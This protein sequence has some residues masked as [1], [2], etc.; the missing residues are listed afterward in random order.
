[1]DEQAPAGNPQARDGQE[2]AMGGSEAAPEAAE[3]A[4]AGAG[5]EGQ[6]AQG[7]QPSPSGQMQTGDDEVTRSQERVPGVST[8]ATPSGIRLR[9]KFPNPISMKIQAWFIL[10]IHHDVVVEFHE[11]A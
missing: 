4:G 1:M 9:T 11:A 7:L 6:R 8:I 2:R 10:L 5:A 3:Q